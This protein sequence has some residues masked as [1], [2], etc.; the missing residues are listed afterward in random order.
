MNQ[1]H[2]LPQDFIE[3]KN[4]DYSP[5]AY[6]RRRFLDIEPEC[7]F[8]G[9][10]EQEF[11]DWQMRFRDIYVRCLGR[12]PNPAAEL[13]VRCEEEVT[14]AAYTRLKIS[15]AAD[16]F[17]RIP[18]YLF[19]PNSRNAND[20]T[21]L[22]P[23]GHGRGKVDPAGIAMTESD[24]KHV[25]GY[26]YNYAEQFAERG[27]VT[28]APDL[29]LFGERTDH[30]E[31]VYGFIEIEEG[32]HWCD[33]NFA[34]GMYLGFNVLTLHVFDMTRCIDFL[35][36]RPEVDPDR[37]GVVGLSQGGTTALFS[38]AFDKRIKVA[39]VSGYLNS[40]RHFPLVKSQTC[41]SQIVPGLLQYGDHPEV[42]GLICP[43]PAFYEMGIN[44]PIFSV[45]A[46]RETYRRVALM[47]NS[48]GVP[49][50]LGR[51]EFEGVHEFRGRN[52]FEFFE[53]WL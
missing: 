21:V 40:W 34:M 30:K 22:C 13:E 47:Y 23:H 25:A 16:R 38:A 52:I 28:L 26:N 43:R 8:T 32:D 10:T 50:R 7:R 39:G 17:S 31:S 42:A 1:T 2:Q 15:F 12:I 27:Y 18:A 20:R 44:D 45:E 9:S 37:I 41:G 51:E 49:E 29:R 14:T 46:S 36:S 6:W 19:L 11:A 48:A 4:E 24:R 35:Q 33:N 53:R 5:L 3:V